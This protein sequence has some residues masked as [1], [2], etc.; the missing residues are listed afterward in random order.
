M[1]NGLIDGMESFHAHDQTGC[2]RTF[3][4]L[5]FLMKIFF[6]KSLCWKSPL[7]MKTVISR[8][9][10]LFTN[11]IRFYVD[12]WQSYWFLCVYYATVWNQ[13]C[14]LIIETVV[15]RVVHD[16]C[17]SVLIIR[18][19]VK[20]VQES[21]IIVFDNPLCDDLHNLL[22]TYHDWAVF[23]DCQQLF[24]KTRYCLL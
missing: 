18:D 23:F 5:F 4:S 1:W 12:S 15:L 2:T 3:V 20:S 11:L 13:V 9:A 8:A 7:C 24:V 6:L 22:V 21:L 14:D 17:G 10:C 16:R 19:T